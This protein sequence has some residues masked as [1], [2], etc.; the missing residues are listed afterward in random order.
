ML[1]RLYLLVKP[2]KMSAKRFRQECKKH[3]EMSLKVPYLSKYEVRLIESEPTDTH[4]PYLNLGIGPIDAIGE[5][6]FENEEAY[7]K[8]LKSNIRK[9]WFKHGKE[10]IGKLKPFVTTDSIS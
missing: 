1:R 7:K 5:C 2:D 3:Y 6:W 9:K 8:Y 4:V 10:F